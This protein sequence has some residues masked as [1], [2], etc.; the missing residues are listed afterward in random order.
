VPKLSSRPDPQALLLDAIRR[1]D[2]LATARLTRQWVHR[3]GVLSLMTFRTTTLVSHEGPEA[4]GWLLEQLEP[5]VQ[6]T[7]APNATPVEA[8]K[9][10]VAAPAP[11]PALAVEEAFAS[12]TEAFPAIP[13]AAVDLASVV[14]AAIEPLIEPLGATPTISTSPAPAPSTLADLRAWLSGGEQHRRV[15]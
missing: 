14:P 6:E 2:G 5:S 11:A 1:R 8:G 9:E 10:A 15:S 4:S 3:R 7:V 12:L 13:L